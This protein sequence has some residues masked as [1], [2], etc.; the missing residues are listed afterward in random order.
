[1]VI[2]GCFCIFATDKPNDM[3]ERVYRPPQ[4]A[5]MKIT[6]YLYGWVQ[7]KL[8]GEVRVTEKKV[9]CLQHLKGAKKA[10]RMET[11]YDMTGEP[12]KEAL[13]ATRRNCIAAGLELD[14]ETT[15]KIYGVSRAD[16]ELYF[17][18][19]CPNVCLTNG[20]V[21]RPWNNDVC[22]GRQQTAALQHVIRDAFWEDVVDYDRRY[23]QEHQG[24]R[25]TVS[26]MLE[27]FCAETGISDV[28]TD[29][30]RREW[31]RRTKRIR[32]GGNSLP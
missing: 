10:L 6:D 25:Y 1:M 13:S 23:A 16:L 12:T 26:D 21:L 27:A 2:S 15:T 24:E 29:T 9:V 19:E 20:G 18:V 30:M 31:Q 5:W 8:T 7:H 17:P 22:F 3:T 28:Y 11:N 14:E 4:V 32:N